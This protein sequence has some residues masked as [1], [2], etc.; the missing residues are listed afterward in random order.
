MTS[1]MQ[2]CRDLIIGKPRLYGLLDRL[3]IKPEQIGNK[4]LLDNE[5]VSKIREALRSQTD[6]KPIETV[7]DRPQT[8]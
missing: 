7:R 1:L 6:R 3:D 8:G 2:L 5:Q 4:R